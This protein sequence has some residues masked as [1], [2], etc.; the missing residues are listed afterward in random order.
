MDEMSRSGS[1]RLVCWNLEWCPLPSSRSRRGKVAGV[2][3]ARQEPDIVC[4]TEARLGWFSDGGGA[5][6]SSEPLGETHS[7]HRHDGRKIL[8]WSRWGWSD[9]D[10]VGS[11][12]IRD[13]GRF[14]AA[15]TST[16]VGPVRVVGVVIPYRGSNVA[17]GSRDRTSW[18]DHRRYLAA[19][20]QIV[21][22]RT[23]PTVVV[24]DFNQ[25]HP[26]DPDY[27]V[28]EELHTEM[29]RSLGDLRIVTGGSAAGI[30]GPLIDHVA[31]SSEI[32]AGELVAWPA[33][34][35]GTEVSDHPGFRIDLQL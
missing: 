4:L 19:L 33:T 17:H 34:Q 26:F 31:L 25:R 24:G 20:Q 2:T 18:E 22:N 6:V 23:L 29:L 35:E 11:E 15:T 5:V 3:I 9:V 30:D 27:L 21:N 8:L 12:N 10:R 13:L 28:P 16:P 32:H 1:V 14:V 7:M